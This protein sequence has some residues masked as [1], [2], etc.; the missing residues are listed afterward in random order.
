MSHDWEKQAVVQEFTERISDGDF[1]G[2]YDRLKS[3]LD[4]AGIL[5]DRERQQLL[6]YWISKER[7]AGRTGQ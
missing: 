2:D 3:D 1:A 7:E 4:A 6:Q 5:S